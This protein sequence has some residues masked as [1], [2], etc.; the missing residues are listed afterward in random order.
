MAGDTNLSASG[1]RQ[2]ARPPPGQCVSRAWSQGSEEAG[3]RGSRGTA[4]RLLE[5][6]RRE[7]FQ[8]GGSAR[9][10]TTE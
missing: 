10:P 7:G 6:Q 8:Q 1:V 3:G 9:F 2:T 4:G 5:A